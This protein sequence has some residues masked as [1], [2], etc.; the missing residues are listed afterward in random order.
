LQHGPEPG[1]YV[2]EKAWQ[3]NWVKEEA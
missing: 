2:K 1:V 3:S